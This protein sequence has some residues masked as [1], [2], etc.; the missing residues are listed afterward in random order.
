MS[1]LTVL[2]KDAHGK[3][4]FQLQKD[5]D[6]LKFDI[7]QEET[8][9]KKIAR[10]V[11]SI[12]NAREAA[13]AV[14][15]KRALVA[16]DAAESPKSVSPAP[17]AADIRMV[18]DDVIFSVVTSH[19]TPTPSSRKAKAWTSRPK[20]WTDIVEHHAE[21]G[22]ES[23]CKEYANELSKFEG[24][25]KKATLNRWK[26]EKNDSKILKA[27]NVRLPKYGKVVEEGLITD[28]TKRIDLGL[29]IDN[30]ILR[31][32][33]LERLKGT[34]Q[35]A[36]L[37]ENGGK[38]VFGH[39]WSQRFWRRNGFSNRAATSKMRD[40]PAD[41][42]EKKETCSRIAANL[43]HNYNI[44]ADFIHGIDETNALFVSEKNRT[45]SAKGAKEFDFWEVVC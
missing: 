37:K 4:R 32:L 11:E 43:I 9:N 26:R 8:A 29:L 5:L 44:P 18:I 6:D 7:A 41:L 24:M 34:S 45:M 36:M 27:P 39:S 16:V 33:L 22:Y 30:T 40:L 25:T 12:S 15:S 3:R 13:K 14:R 42:N 35:T 28:I 17:G 31:N 19:V 2:T 1:Y 21:Y 38:H 23:V 10:E 20:Y